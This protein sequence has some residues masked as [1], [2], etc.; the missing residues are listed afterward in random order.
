MSSDPSRNYDIPRQYLTIGQGV[1]CEAP[2]TVLTV[3]GSCVSVTMYSDAQRLGGV[4]HAL[5]PN[6]RDHENG[7]KFNKYKY[8]DSSVEALLKEMNRRGV[9]NSALECKVFGGASALFPHE[10]SVGERNVR[11]ALEA[12][13]ARGVRVKTMDVGGHQGR[14]L[15]FVT[16][17]GE[18]FIKRLKNPIR[19]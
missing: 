3:L 13:S 5:M 11:A 2:T 15:L 4:F 16:H 14:K 10:A 18:V 8:V 9:P 6:W 19:Q 1:V 7:T 12:L 17:T